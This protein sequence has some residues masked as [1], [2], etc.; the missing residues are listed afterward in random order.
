M[1]LPQ[2]VRASDGGSGPVWTRAKARGRNPVGGFIGG[3]LALIGLVVLA[4]AI[5]NG[6]FGKGGA[7]LDGWLGGITHAFGGKTNVA[8]MD[9]SMPVEPASAPAS[10]QPVS[11]SAATTAQAPAQASAHP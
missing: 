7:V 2:A 5:L 6:G 8:A 9:N 11:G 1:R 3:I 10:S 4:L